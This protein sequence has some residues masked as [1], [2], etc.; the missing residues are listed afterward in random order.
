MSRDLLNECIAIPGSLPE[1]DG[2]FARANYKL[3]Q[4][5]YEQGKESEGDKF[6]ERARVMRRTLS[7][8]TT[9][10]DDE[11]IDTYDRLNLWMLW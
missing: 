9:L 7:E 8:Q 4:L 2:Q 5:Y 10:D 3:S 11:S 1:G 6:H